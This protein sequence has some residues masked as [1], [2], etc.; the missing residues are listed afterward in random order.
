V[1]TLVVGGNSNVDVLRGRVGIAE[2]N[3]GNVDVTGLLDSLGVGAG[4]RDDDEAGLLER[5][6]DI[7]GKATG[8]EA[9]GN[10]DSS[11]V[12]SK[13]ED[14]TLA[15]GSSRDGANIGGVVNG[16]DNSG[17]EDNLLPTRKSVTRPQQQ[18]SSESYQVLPMLRTLTPSAR[19]FQR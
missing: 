5:A 6:R 4:I 18:I 7:V 11:S 14:S 10:S 15:V 12:G 8:G 17:G 1:A 3:H 13:L 9:A 16:D 19:V 2:G